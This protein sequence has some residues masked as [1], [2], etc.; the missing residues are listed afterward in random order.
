MLWEFRNLKDGFLSDQSYLQS[1]V[2]SDFDYWCIIQRDGV[3]ILFQINYEL[4]IKN[5]I[6]ESILIEIRSV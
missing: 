1:S 2:L 5:S 4:V 3:N 6:I